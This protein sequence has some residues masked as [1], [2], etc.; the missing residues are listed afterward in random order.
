MPT[1]YELLG[2]GRS[3]TSDEIR[4][5]FRREAKKLHPDKAGGGTAGMVGLNEAYE[6]LKD[7]GKRKAYDA[8]LERKLPPRPQP[9]Y[10][11]PFEY[12][13]RIFMPLDAA[14]RQALTDLEQAL[15]ELEYDVYDDLYVERFG[16]AVEHA[17]EALA[18]AQTRLFSAPWPEPLA[19]GLNFYRQGLRQAD[20]A[21]ED[22][23]AFTGNFDVDVL[24]EGRALL[25]GAARMLDEARGGLL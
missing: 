22:F 21:V 25:V 6:T 2:L 24:V 4:R 17:A 9:V 7:P 18:A 3:A 15:Q 14:V 10:Y 19:S 20:D 5:A 8:T 23:E 1:Y 16:T 11:D 13:L 12:K